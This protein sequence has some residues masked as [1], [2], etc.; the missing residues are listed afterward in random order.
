M[1]V[2]LVPV[3]FLQF[4]GWADN[5][6][7]TAGSFSRILHFNGNA[8][9]EYVELNNIGYIYGLDVTSDMVV[10][11]GDFNAVAGGMVIRWYRQ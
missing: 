1:S 4:T 2:E 10:A 8:F 5:D 9:N 7:F 6:L 3:L 11:V